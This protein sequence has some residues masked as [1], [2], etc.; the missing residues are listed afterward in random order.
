MT[1]SQSS[2]ATRLTWL[3]GWPG[4]F[5]KR[6]VCRVNLCEAIVYCFGVAN[7]SETWVCRVQQAE[8]LT[9]GCKHLKSGYM[10]MP[11]AVL[12]SS[13]A[14]MTSLEIA[15]TLSLLLACPC[16]SY[17]IK[18]GYTKEGDLV[19]LTPYV[20][21]LR[22]LTKAV[23]ASNMRVLLSDRD[24]EELAKLVDEAT[25]AAVAAVEAGDD[26]AAA[27]SGGGDVAAAAGST[28]DT[29]SGGAAGG[30]AAAGGTTVTDMQSCLRLA[31]IDNFQVEFVAANLPSRDA[32]LLSIMRQKAQQP[33]LGI[34]KVA[35]KRWWG[36]AHAAYIMRC[37][38]RR[39][40]LCYC[41]L[42]PHQRLHLVRQLSCSHQAPAS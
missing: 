5:F 20:G 30:G 10:T 18:Q 42:A 24:T 6:N 34:V 19:I 32:D 8:G 26:D 14:L 31:T 25:A 28:G 39:T 4:K 12:P 22:R 35:G 17:L 40:D 3:L 41:K 9:S 1:A 13:L 29:G 33:V 2:T 37:A 21:Q 38:A 11:I 23:A 27:A 16:C 15:C 7:S 36:Y